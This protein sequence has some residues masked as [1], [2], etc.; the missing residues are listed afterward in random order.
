MNLF[1]EQGG[2][3]YTSFTGKTGT[4]KLIGV[5]TNTETVEPLFKTNIKQ[6]ILAC[7]DEFKNITTGKYMRIERQKVMLDF[8]KGNI[9][10]I[11]TSEVKLNTETKKKTGRAV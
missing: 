5:E 2:Y 1:D 8:N 3:N 10:P 6:S 11:E 7:I 4:W 9:K